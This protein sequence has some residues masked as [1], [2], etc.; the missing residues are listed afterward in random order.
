VLLNLI[1]NALDALAE[2]PPAQPTLEVLAGENLAGTECWVRVRDNGPG[3]AREAL[4][5]IWS[6]FYT[7]KPSGTG[8]GLAI[9]KKLVEAHGGTIEVASQPGAGAEFTIAL[10]KLRTDA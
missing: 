6:P 7:S 8:L 3:I 4:A 9:A 5:Q 10:P 1:G 2:K